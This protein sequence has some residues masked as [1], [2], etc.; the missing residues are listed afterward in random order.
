MLRREEAM[1]RRL[2][3]SKIKRNEG[4]KHKGKGKC[5]EREERERERGGGGEGYSVGKEG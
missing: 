1:L 2:M 5:E 3:W 4:V